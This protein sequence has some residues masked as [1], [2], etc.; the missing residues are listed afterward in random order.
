MRIAHFVSGFPVLSETFVLDE[1]AAFAGEGFE[2]IV[3]T[4]RPA[5]QDSPF[6]SCW[7]ENPF[8]RPT[9]ILYPGSFRWGETLVRS[10]RPA[11]ILSSLLSAGLRHPREMSRLVY[12]ARRIVETAPILRDYGVGHC[13]AHFAHYPSALAWGCAKLLGTTYSWNAHSYDLFLYRAHLDR[14]IR[15]A[16]LIFPVS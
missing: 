8:S 1:I 11:S 2:N 15:D 7:R 16:D 6:L 4:L 5:P 3:V 10:A 13:H 9:A 14:R 12:T